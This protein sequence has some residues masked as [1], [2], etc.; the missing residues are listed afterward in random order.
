MNRAGTAELLDRF[1]AHAR[2]WG[3][4]IDDARPTESSFIGFGHRDGLRV[5]LKVARAKG[6]VLG[7]GRGWVPLWRFA[8]RTFV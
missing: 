3:V 8:V 4:T 1:E 6:E 5:V 2:K 7:P